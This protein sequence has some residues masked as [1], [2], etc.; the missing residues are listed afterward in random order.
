MGSAERT[1]QRDRYGKRG[2]EV[3]SVVDSVASLV[4]GFDPALTG[5]RDA[6]ELVAEFS[7][8]EHLASAGVALAARR[9]AQTD[10]WRRGGHRSAAHWLDHVTGMG[11]GDAVRLLQ[12]AE[13]VET[14][15]ETFEA[16]RS[17]VVSAREAKAIGA[18]EAA[19]PGA[20]RR[21]L[22]SA[23]G[24]ST[25]E[26]E[27]DAAR[28]VAAAAKES[29]AERAE[30]HRA[31]RRVSHGVDPDGMGWGNWRLPIAEHTRI[32]AQLEGERSRVFD[33]ARAADEREPVGAYAADAFCRIFDRAARH[34]DAARGGAP[35]AS[36][37]PRP[38]DAQS[39]GVADEPITGAGHDSAPGQAGEV[40][41]DWSFVKTIVRVD[42]TALDRGAVAPGEVCEIAGQGPIPVAD[43]WRMID[44][45][46]FIAAVTTKGTEIDEVIHLGRQPTVLQKT[47]LEWFSAGE[48]SIEGCTN[49]ARIEIDHVDDWAHTNVT[50]LPDLAS[51]CGHH[52][53]LK[54][55]HGYTYGPRLPTGKR[56]LIPPGQSTGTG[57]EDRPVA[58]GP[59]ELTVHHGEGPPPSDGSAGTAQGGLFDTG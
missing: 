50:R 27:N 20:G 14:A 5:A 28:V 38:S 36:S 42:L 1:S 10:L 25:K 16:L 34:A 45:D 43:V 39:V 33:E 23:P 59:P 24:R 13:V 54:T 49:P 8:L 11:V 55:H 53:D 17:G 48:C 30:R 44:G 32:V 22:D 56:R 21:L 47:A 31:A 52:H 26:T 40:V 51:P 46:A 3:A 7:R 19:D 9:V 15:P 12:T 57:G 6:V 37:A 41:E 18:A 29:E 4:E 58:T 35:A 2:R